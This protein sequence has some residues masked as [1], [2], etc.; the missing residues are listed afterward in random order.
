MTN[1]S[2]TSRIAPMPSL[3]AAWQDVDSS[4]ERFYLTAGI[5]AMEQ[6][7]CEDAQRLAGAPTSPGRHAPRLSLTCVHLQNEHFNIYLTV[8]H[9]PFSREV[10]RQPLAIL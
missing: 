1:L 4:F 7:L 10:R 9:G 8:R 2:T 3:E 6:V 5:Q